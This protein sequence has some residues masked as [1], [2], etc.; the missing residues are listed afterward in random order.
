[1][2]SHGSLEKRG[3]GQFFSGLKCVDGL[4]HGFVAVGFLEKSLEI[5]VA[6]GIEKTETGEMPF[7]PELLGRGGEQQEPRDCAGEGLD[8]VV[9]RSAAR[10]RPCEVMRF[11][12]HEQIPPRLSGLLR[13]LR[14]RG[15]KVQRADHELAV[16]EGIRAGGF[17][18]EAA[19]LVKNTE[20]HLKPAEHFHE[21]L[22]EERGREQHQ[23]P[24]GAAGQVQAVN[25]KAGL[26]RF[27]KTHFVGQKNTRS[28]TGGDFGGD[29]NLVGNQIDAPSGESSCGI[30]PQIAP[31]LEAFGAEFEALH[32]I[33]LPGEKSLFGF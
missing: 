27:A 7:Q 15:E 8:Q 2:L 24:G 4:G 18:R 31:T 32:F 16:E 23:N 20:G 28:E 11:V 14:I 19:F 25:D 9:F 22:V 12:H 33:D 17:E 3:F 5:V 13:A 10:G 26:D 29:G 1:M 21:P 30:L 6:L